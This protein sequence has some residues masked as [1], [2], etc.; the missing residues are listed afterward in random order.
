MPLSRGRRTDR[1]ADQTQVARR[2]GA[3]VELIVLVFD[4]DDEARMPSVFDAAADG[5]AVDEIARRRRG[6]AAAARAPWLKASRRRR[7][8]RPS[9]RPSCG[10][11][12][13]RG[14]ARP[15]AA[16]RSC[17]VKLSAGDTGLGT[18]SFRPMPRNA[19]SR[20]KIQLPIC[21]LAPQ[22][23]PPA[24][25]LGEKLAPP[26]AL[27]SAK[28]S[29]QLDVAPGAAEL[30]ADVEAAPV[31]DVLRIRHRRARHPSAGLS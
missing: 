1:D 7:P 16:N 11:R 4:A 15:S 14:A 26:G 27:N 13:S 19:A 24:K 18:V 2:G 9:R 8:S 29:V 28:F 23:T 12:S 3:E 10:P 30:A 22:M 17:V 20:P 21:R 31:A 6:D 5:P 25:L